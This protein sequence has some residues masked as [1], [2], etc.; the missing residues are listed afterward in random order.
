ME[1]SM[2]VVLVG[3][4]AVAGLSLYSKKANGSYNP[5]VML[6]NPFGSKALPLPKTTPQLG[7]GTPVSPQA[8][9]APPPASIPPAQSTSPEVQAALAALQSLGNGGNS[10][11]V[12]AALNSLKTSPPSSPEAQAAASLLRGL[13]SAG[14]PEIQAALALL[15][16]PPA[17]PFQPNQANVIKPADDLVQDGDVV[18]VD[19]F[20]SGM[21]LPQNIPLVGLVFMNVDS[22]KA[23]GDPTKFLASFV[24]AELRVFGPQTVNRASIV[25]KA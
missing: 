3:L 23:P 20:R 1:T 12:Q 18:N 4:A 25:G 17:N 10:P 14:S 5:L 6:G 13:P 15:Q 9:P 19:M 8:I 2:K 21:N 7:P 11:E 16:N 24:T 22:L